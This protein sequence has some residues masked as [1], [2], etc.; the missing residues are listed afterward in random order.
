MP[1]PIRVYADT[2]VY[3]GVLDEEFAEPSR[4][5]FDQVRD[6]KFELVVSV[7]LR[8]ELEESPIKVRDLFHE[9]RPK[10]RI[11]DASAD[12]IRLQTAYIA[13]Q[14]VGARWEADAFHVALATVAECRIIVSWN[15]RHIVHYEKI[16]RYNGVN[17]ANGY[18]A[19]AI[20]SPQEVIAHED[21]DV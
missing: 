20:H 9:L 11:V 12:V 17:L 3:G 13:A 21:E 19:I 7:L 2:S 6:G 1:L 16:P 8:D 10:C 15:F 5:F 14:I 18:A 4:I